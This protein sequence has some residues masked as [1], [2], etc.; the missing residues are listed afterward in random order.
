[1]RFHLGGAP[2]RA[3]VLG[4]TAVLGLGLASA[5]AFAAG[6]STTV[7]PTTGADP[8]GQDV[9]VTGSGFDPNKNNGFGVYVAFG[10]KNGA[11]WYLNANAFQA[12]KWVHKNASGSATQV[13]MNADGTFDLT[14]TGIKAK[15]TDG[16]GKQ[17]DCLV[18]Q[19]YVLTFAAHG[20]PDRSQDTV[21]P[22]TFVGGE[23]PDPGGGDPGGPGTGDQRV[24]A[25][26]TRTGALSMSMAGTDVTLSEAAPG[27]NS[28]GAL[29]K[30]TVVDARGTDAGWNLVGQMGDLASAEGG[31]IPAANLAWTPNAAVVEDGSGAA[32]TP[33]PQ[34]RG[35]GT[36]QTL[37]T[38]A[39][40]ASGGVFAA[41]AGL[42]LLVPAGVTPGSYTGTLTLTLS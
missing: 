15:Y 28:S 31:T 7:T 24:T 29:H 18:T 32:V 35:L 38:S 21:T 26:V 42:D 33:G 12:T 11:D 17:V 9:H 39:A 10:P 1:M 6:P 3:A 27:G 36:A 4:T 20:M 37:A 30:A 23:N 13:R 41:G 34:V 40:G 25:K 2:R 16:D 22:V 19:C 5:P 14:L 8:D